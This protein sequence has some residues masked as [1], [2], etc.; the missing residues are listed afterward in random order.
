MN[1]P[2]LHGVL[3]QTGTGGEA[4]PGE[5]SHARIVLAEGRVNAVEVGLEVLGHHEELVGDGEVEVAPGI[6]EELG[7]LGLD[8]LQEDHLGTDKAKQGR[9]PFPG[10]RRGS[11]DQ[12]RQLL[13]FHQRLALHDPL[14]TVGQVDVA[15]ALLPKL[16][17]Q[18]VGDAGK[19]RAAQHQKLAGMHL[20]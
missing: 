6:A 13:Q 18:P 1:D 15:T 8:R 3:E 5:G 20:G 16:S 19:D 14:R 4:R 17:G 12:L 11:A 9:G 10:P 7:Q 2:Q